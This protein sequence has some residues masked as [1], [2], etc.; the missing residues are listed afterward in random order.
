[1]SRDPYIQLSTRVMTEAMLIQ[2]EADRLRPFLALKA[3]KTL[4]PTDKR[5]MERI[6]KR[7]DRREKSL[8][9]YLCQ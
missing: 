8:S 4:T 6:Y 3:V 9:A 5:D 2:Q 1:M 7:M